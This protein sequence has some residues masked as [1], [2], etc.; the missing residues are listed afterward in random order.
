MSQEIFRF[1]N[2][3]WDVTGLRL[4]ML[5]DP[6]QFGPIEVPIDD[7]LM[8]SVSLYKDLDEQRITDMDQG[9]RDT[10]ILVVLQ[11]N[12]R[13][14]VVDGNHRLLRRHRDGCETIS[15]YV[16]PWNVAAPFVRPAD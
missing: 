13:G 14:R 3:I 1:E 8:H 12:G 9:R 5:Q 2:V 15:C 4:A 6:A 16:L 11:E 7:A 10:P